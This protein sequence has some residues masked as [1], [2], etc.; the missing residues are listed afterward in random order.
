MSGKAKR[1]WKN[2]TTAHSK[3]SGE[4]M[5]TM[6]LD[7]GA[8]RPIIDV[9][10]YGPDVLVEKRVSQPRELREFMGKYPVLW[11]NV[12][13][14]GDGRIIYEVGHMFGLHQL[15][16][17]DVVHHHQRAKVEEYGEHTFVVVRMVDYTDRLGTEQVSLFLGKGFVLTF[18]ERP[19]RDSIDPVR[20]RLRRGTGRIRSSDA[21]YLVY[22]LID[23]VVDGFFPV[24][25]RYSDRM[26]AL[27]THLIENPTADNVSEIHE[28]KTE[29]LVL[30]RA[31]WPHREAL[32]HLL[33]DPNPLFSEDTRIFLRD[34][35]DHTVQLIDLVETYR[36]LCADLRDLQLS[37][38]SH[39]M[40]EIMKV[41]TIISTIFIPLTFIAG[42]YGMNFKHES[43]PWNMP[44]LDWF[45]GYPAS[46]CI[47]AITTVCMIIFFRNKGWLGGGKKSSDNDESK[48]Q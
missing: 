21:G 12:D 24:L 37:S 32:N 26:E 2:L 35:Y 45:Y 29:L 31:L 5:G 6:V 13:G 42:V 22:A 11:V 33:R 36:E 25:D 8:H 39:R 43:S 23:A 3:P 34:V 41:L 20:D 30:R 38:A 46:L 17:E 1:R 19:G 40:N 27:E 28:I 15:I 9:M 14:L 16:I 18:Q 48:A 10:A 4:V 7:P 47:M 44:E